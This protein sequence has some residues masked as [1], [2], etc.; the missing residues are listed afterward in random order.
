M[1][2][3]L[4]SVCTVYSIKRSSTVRRCLFKEGAFGPQ[5]QRL[6]TFCECHVISRGP[7]TG[8]NE[9]CL[10]HPF[11]QHHLAPCTIHWERAKSPKTLSTSG[12]DR[13][14]PRRDTRASVRSLLSFRYFFCQTCFLHGCKRTCVTLSFSKSNSKRVIQSAHWQRTLL[15]ECIEKYRRIT[16]FETAACAACA[17]L[18]KPSGLLFA[19]S[20]RMWGE[21]QITAANGEDKTASFDS[22]S[23]IS[24][25]FAE[26]EELVI[27]L[28]DFIQKNPLWPIISYHFIFF[29]LRLMSAT[30]RGGM[31]RRPSIS[32]RYLSLQVF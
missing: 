28:S 19:C 10:P 29:F 21:I 2:V 24:H 23:Y 27:Y 32:G 16:L 11:L 1:S 30:A 31:N 17:P 26:Q 20:L 14:H 5:K 18:A 3:L 15:T 9:S 7:Y 4:K 13:V 8:F 6:L 12:S 22:N 25:R